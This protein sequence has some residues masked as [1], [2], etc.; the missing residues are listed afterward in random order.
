MKITQALLWARAVRQT[1]IM[2][3]VVTHTDSMQCIFQA[4][5]TTDTRDVETLNA[6]K[7]V[8]KCWRHSARSVLIDWRRVAGTHALWDVIQ[9]HHITHCLQLPVACTL[10][11]GRIYGTLSNGPMD[12]SCTV[13]GHPSCSMRGVLRDMTV[14]Y[15]ENI[16]NAPDN[17]LNECMEL[18]LF[19]FEFNGITYHSVY[20]ALQHAFPCQNELTKRQAIESI[21]MGIEVNG[22]WLDFAWRE[23]IIE[24]ESAYGDSLLLRPDGSSVVT[25]IE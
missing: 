10:H 7:A 4:F 11:P 2:Q 1:H 18:T 13:A 22:Y 5:D 19:V 14:E 8:S 25:I 15:S 3:R 6:L 9:T 12:Q 20:S 16:F 17:E 24:I 23:E 21:S